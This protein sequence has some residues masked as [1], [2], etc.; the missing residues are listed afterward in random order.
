MRRVTPASLSTTY[1]GGLVRSVNTGERRLYADGS[2]LKQL[3]FRQ[4]DG[5]EPETEARLRA[6]DRSL[7][8]VS[9]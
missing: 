7:K 3:S 2:V 9:R 1:A 6:R 5:S 8:R 4:R